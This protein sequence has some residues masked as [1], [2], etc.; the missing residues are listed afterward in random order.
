MSRLA[1]IAILAASGARPAQDDWKPE[2]RLNGAAVDVT[3]VQ[4]AVGPFAERLCNGEILDRAFKVPPAGPIGLQA[5]SGKF[6]FR[7]IRVRMGS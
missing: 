2:A 6:E 1:L 3:A 5:E 4:V 7:R